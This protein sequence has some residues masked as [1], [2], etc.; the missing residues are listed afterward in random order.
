MVV[1]SGTLR[2][3]TAGMV[4]TSGT[5]RDLFKFYMQTTSSAVRNARTL[6]LY[7]LIMFTPVIVLMFLF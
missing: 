3:G 7:T 2:E 1:T 5:L 4:V 6:A